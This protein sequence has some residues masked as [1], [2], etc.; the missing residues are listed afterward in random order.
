MFVIDPD[1]IKSPP[2]SSPQ[3]QEQDGTATWSSGGRTFVLLGNQIDQET[4]R[5]LI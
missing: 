1:H 5:K 4:L 3:F 2:G